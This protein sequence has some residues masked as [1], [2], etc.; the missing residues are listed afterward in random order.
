MS[1]L[2]F[3]GLGSS[4]YGGAHGEHGYKTFTHMR[5]TLHKPCHW[6]FEFGGLR[7]APYTKYS[8]AGGSGKIF[9]TLFEMAPNI[10]VVDWAAL[11]R[12]AAIVAVMA[13]VLYVG[14]EEPG[15]KGHLSLATFG[16]GLVKIGEWL[17]A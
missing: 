8:F 5:A 15:A 12:A 14:M 4:G 16:A 11:R 6:A 10:R 9:R 1:S 13:G 3:G 17:K 7:Y 2:P